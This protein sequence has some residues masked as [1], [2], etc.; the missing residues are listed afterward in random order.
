MTSVVPVVESCRFLKTKYSQSEHLCG[1]WIQIL[2]NFGHNISIIL[3]KI[4]CPLY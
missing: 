2:T 1:K 3:S 4:E